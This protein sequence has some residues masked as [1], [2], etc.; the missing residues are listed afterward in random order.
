MWLLLFP[1]LSESVH[2]SLLV[3][4]CLQI[5]RHVAA[6]FMVC[7]FHFHFCLYFRMFYLI[8]S[9][10]FHFNIVFLST[11]NCKHELGL[12]IKIEVSVIS[13][14]RRLRLITL[15]ETLIIPDITKTES[16]NCFIIHCFEENNDKRIIAAITVYFQTLKNVQI[17]TVFIKQSSAEKLNAFLKKVLLNLY[18]QVIS[19]FLAGSMKRMEKPFLLRCPWTWHC[20]P[21]TWHWSWKSCIARATYRLF[22]NL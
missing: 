11:W 2:S 3:Y 9:Y 15:T 13:R 4:V 18:L 7:I 1:S 12:I 16:N 17:F 20:C 22:T 19:Q 21:W 14:S 8:R 10:I 5:L 6:I